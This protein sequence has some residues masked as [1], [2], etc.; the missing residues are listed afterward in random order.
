MPFTQ[1]G[2][3]CLAATLVAA[4]VVVGGLLQTGLG[5]VFALYVGPRVET[6]GSLVSVATATRITAVFVAVSAIVSS[7]LAAVVYN[8]MRRRLRR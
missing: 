4:G 5:T 3:P 7:T 6:G 1:L 8:R 2:H